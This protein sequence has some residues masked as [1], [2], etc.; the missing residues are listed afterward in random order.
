[1]AITVWDTPHLS[2]NVSNFDMNIS[3]E[4]PLELGVPKKK[5]LPIHNVMPPNVINL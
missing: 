4:I 2:P 3:V 5:T 1:M